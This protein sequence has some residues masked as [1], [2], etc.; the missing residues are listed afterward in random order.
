MIAINGTQEKCHEW[1][2]RGNLRMIVIMTAVHYVASW[3]WF[4]KFQTPL[5]FIG[6]GIQKFVG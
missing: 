6:Q 4:M 2:N 3:L 5:F 1:T